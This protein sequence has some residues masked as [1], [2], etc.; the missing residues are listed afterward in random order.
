MQR[1]KG[2]LLPFEVSILEVG[3]ELHRHGVGR[4]HGF[5][6]AK[7]LQQR[8]GDA[9]RPGY[10]TLYRALD[11]MADAGLLRSEW[12]DPLIAAREGRP[13]RRFYSVTAAGETALA[14][15][16][17]A[18]RSAMPEFTKGLAPS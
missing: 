8:D 7:E 17:V 16:P 1:K 13:R 3:L 12:D 4:F 14:H 9:R 18:G 6:L 15:A 10:G 11:R 2:T 5:L